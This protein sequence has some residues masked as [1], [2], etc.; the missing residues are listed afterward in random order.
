MIF[1]ED[2]S[3]LSREAEA[4]SGNPDQLDHVITKNDWCKDLESRDI[5]NIRI[6]LNFPL[7]SYQYFPDEE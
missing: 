2:V 7:D 6:F 5:N 1:I 4:V 3:I